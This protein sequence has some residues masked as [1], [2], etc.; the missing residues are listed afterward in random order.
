[1]LL[2]QPVEVIR[3]LMDFSDLISALPPVFASISGLI[4]LL[5]KSS[6]IAIPDDSKA[7]GSVIFFVLVWVIYLI[8]LMLGDKVTF[9][10]PFLTLIALLLGMTP[11][12]IL[13][14]IN[15]FNINVGRG[16]GSLLFICGLFFIL[17]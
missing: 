10:S 11:L 14:I 1:M 17:F 7:L 3:N 2:K 8:V 16:K 6:P 4:P 5:I 15:I 13:F 12:C 9:Y